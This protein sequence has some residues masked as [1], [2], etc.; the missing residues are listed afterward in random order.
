MEYL[1]MKLY[2]TQTASLN[3]YSKFGQTARDILHGRD[4]RAY[5]APGP[6]G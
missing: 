2:Y 6:S 1:G 3:R 5:I 4:A